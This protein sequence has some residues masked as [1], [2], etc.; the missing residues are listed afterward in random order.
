MPINLT[1]TLS[2]YKKADPIE[3]AASAQSDGS[4]AQDSGSD[5]QEA[6]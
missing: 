4:E 5:S 2:A 3:A 1:T 6:Q